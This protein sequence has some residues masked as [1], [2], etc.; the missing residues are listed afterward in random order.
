MLF[1]FASSKANRQPSFRDKPKNLF[2]HY[3]VLRESV[4]KF[5]G[6]HLLRTSLIFTT[7]STFVSE[8]LTNRSRFVSERLKILAALK[9]PISLLLMSYTA[10]FMRSGSQFFLPG[11]F[12]YKFSTKIT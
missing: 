4:S 9:L 12:T 11:M 7:C 10:N 3:A 2:L 1:C 6:S 8:S 5:S